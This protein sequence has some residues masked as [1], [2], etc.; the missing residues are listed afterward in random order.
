MSA[1]PI[2]CTTSQR[3]AQATPRG[4]RVLTGAI[5]AVRWGWFAPRARARQC[6]FSRGRTSVPSTEARSRRRH[7]AQGSCASAAC[8][9]RGWQ[10]GK[11]RHRR[12]GPAHLGQGGPAAANRPFGGAAGPSPRRPKEGQSSLV[13][14]EGD[15]R[16]SPRLRSWGKP[17]AAR[18]DGRNGLLRASGP[19]LG[20]G[21]SS[22]STSDAAPPWPSSQ[23]HPPLDRQP[24][25][26]ATPSR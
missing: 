19:A 9:R 25:C 1:R 15:G 12:P 6:P 22:C 8:A 24:H 7:D 5:N 26:S 11:G 4:T 10:R 21:P 17:C 20:V 2:V 23:P 13:A 16:C 3:V 18:S 14:E